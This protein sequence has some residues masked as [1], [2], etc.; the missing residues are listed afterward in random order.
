MSNLNKICSVLSR[1]STSRPFSH[2]WTFFAANTSYY[3]IISITQQKSWRKKKQ[4]HFLLF[5]SEKTR[6]PITLLKICHMTQANMISF[7]Q[8]HANGN[9]SYNRSFTIRIE[10]IFWCFYKTQTTQLFMKIKHYLQRNSKLCCYHLKCKKH[11]MIVG[12]TTNKCRSS[13]QR[14]SVRKGD[15]GNFAKFRGKHLCQSLFFNKVAGLKPS[16]S[17]KKRSGTGV[18]CKFCEISK[19]NFFTQNTSGRLLLQVQEMYLRTLPETV[20]YQGHLDKREVLPRHHYKE[21]EFC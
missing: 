17:L 16:I 3:A 19:N 15:L 21:R 11:R 4:K 5:R 13:H 9:N 2:E 7:K 6:Q 8:T 1:F 12:F 10:Q 20:V 18:S 14:G